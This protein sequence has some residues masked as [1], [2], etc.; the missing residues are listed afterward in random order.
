MFIG[1]KT[2]DIIHLIEKFTF[3]QRKLV[4]KKLVIELADKRFDK[5]EKLI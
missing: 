1:L 2:A 5:I 3:I 4:Y